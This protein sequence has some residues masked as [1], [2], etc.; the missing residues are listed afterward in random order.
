[1]II[2][3]DRRFGETCRLIAAPEVTPTMR[4]AMYSI[5]SSYFQNTDMARFTSDL[6]EKDWVL[7][8]LDNKEQ[9]IGFTTIQIRTTQWR[10][11]CIR[12]IFSGDTIVERAYW[13][14]NLLIPAF[15]AFMMHVFEIDPVV[16][17]F[18]F[19][20]S[21]G[22]R[23]YR[24]LPTY[25]RNYVPAENDAHDSTI[26]PLLHHIASEKFGTCYKPDKGIVSYT[27]VKDYMSPDLLI[28]EETRR[29]NPHIS[30]FIGRNP[31]FIRGD[32]LACL[33]RVSPDNL[34]P[35]AHRI[36]RNSKKLLQVPKGWSV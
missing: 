13:Q 10:G 14:S 26:L 1:M 28:V 16:P 24:I 33:A 31:G 19:L 25:F 32:E 11:D 36:L 2:S 21:K 5:H 35:I 4:K 7:Q 3:P 22:Y 12:Y 30:Y 34:T 20:I 27:C 23:T 8:L 29:K 9:T 15:G 18:W 6:N 17:L